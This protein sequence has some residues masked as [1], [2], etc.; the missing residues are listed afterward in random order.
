MECAMSEKVTNRNRAVLDAALRLAAD[1]G[2]RNIK[3]R[4]IAAEAQVALG[5]VNNAFGTM[6]ALRDAVMQAAVDRRVHAVVAQGITDRHPSA[7]A[8]PASL[9]GEALESL[10]A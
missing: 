10:A 3:R 7:M 6:D 5:T 9:R 1:R 2:Y 4:E 8:A